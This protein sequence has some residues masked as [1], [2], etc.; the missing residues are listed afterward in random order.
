MAGGAAGLEAITPA[1]EAI[2]AY[3]E[4]TQYSPPE[5]PEPPKGPPPT[6]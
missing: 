3:R 5:K 6:P 1:L 4:K 2:D